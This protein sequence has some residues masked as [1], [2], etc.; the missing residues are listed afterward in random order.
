MV[1]IVYLGA[2][3]NVPPSSQ[4]TNIPPALAIEDPKA[5]AVAR[6]TCGVTLFAFHV[7][8]AGATA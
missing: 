8:M 6:R 7:I 2:G 3:L 5:M 1:A 4:V